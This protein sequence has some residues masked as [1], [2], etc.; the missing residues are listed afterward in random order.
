MNWKYFSRN[1]K[2]YFK[3][4]QCYL[5]HIK[6]FIWIKLLLIKSGTNIKSLK[7]SF[8]TKT[9]FISIKY[10]SIKYNGNEKKNLKIYF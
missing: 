6:Y 8:Q 5:K 2:K 10:I 3:V 7:K 4:M 1:E 9:Y